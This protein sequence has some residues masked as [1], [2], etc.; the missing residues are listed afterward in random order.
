METRA[1][2]CCRVDGG[3]EQHR[4]GLARLTEREGVIGTLFLFFFQAE[5]G[6]RDLT[7]TGVQ[8][9]ALPISAGTIRMP[10]GD[11][12]LEARVVADERRVA[13]ELLP[14]ERALAVRLCGHAGIPDVTLEDEIGRAHV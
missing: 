5:D 9:C 12:V 13:I 1:E 10:D 8:T 2:E 3:G 4:N 7:V 14:S 11:T 6:I